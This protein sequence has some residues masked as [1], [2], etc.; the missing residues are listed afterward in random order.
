MAEGQTDDKVSHLF[1]D[2]V[3]HE[4]LKHFMVGLKRI[5]RVVKIIYSA[6]DEFVLD[7]FQSHESKILTRGAR[8]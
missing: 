1:D 3:T 2:T 6:L 5:K 4:G 8:L 7:V